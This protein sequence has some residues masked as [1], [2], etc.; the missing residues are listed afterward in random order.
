MICKESISTT[1]SCFLVYYDLLHRFYNLLLPK[2]LNVLEAFIVQ[3]KYLA[4]ALGHRLSDKLVMMT[5]IKLSNALSQQITSKTTSK[6]PYDIDSWVIVASAFLHIFQTQATVIPRTE[7]IV[8]TNESESMT[9]SYP[10]RH[11]H[12]SYR[13]QSKHVPLV[14]TISKVVVYAANAP[15]NTNS[16]IMPRPQLIVD[17]II[18]AQE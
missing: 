5:F 9:T 16:D 11:M 13:N 15:K 12:N 6:I 10:N 8:T 18:D 1:Y 14:L 7:D 3:F 4:T 17:V 2:T